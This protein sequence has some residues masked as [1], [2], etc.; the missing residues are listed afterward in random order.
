MSDRAR[1]RT[2][3]GPNAVIQLI[4]ALRRA[5]R[6]K[7]AADALA[8][9]GEQGWIAQ[10]PDAMVDERRVAAVHAAV[11]GA[12]EAEEGRRIFAEAGRA[13]GDYLLAHR[14]PPAAAWA[15]RRTPPALSARLL[16]AAIRR[17][18]W[19]FAGSGEFRAR[20]D[21]DVRLEIRGNPLR[22]SAGRC[23]AGCVWHAAV[24]ERLFQSLVSPRARAVEAAC[25]SRGAA[26]CAF[27][28]S[29]TGPSSQPA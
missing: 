3:I 24:F 26:A 20:A 15:L 21:R 22:P 29:W 6:L 1:L 23:D 8:A 27:E 16:V 10:P 28:V 12:L 9:V 5:G 7:V 2:R 18:A 14:I 4:E 17:H 11:L 13:T 19:T 25:E